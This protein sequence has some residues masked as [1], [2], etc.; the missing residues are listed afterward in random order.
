MGKLDKSIDQIAL[1]YDF[2]AKPKGAD[3]FDA[4]FMP[5]AASLKVN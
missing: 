1:T 2:K 4:S 5:P 3:I